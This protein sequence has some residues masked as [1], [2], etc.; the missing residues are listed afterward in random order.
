[1]RLIRNK[2]RQADMYAQSS[3]SGEQDRDAQFYSWLIERTPE[4]RE[5]HIRLFP[6]ILKSFIAL[7]FVIGSYL[8]WHSDLDRRELVFAKQLVYDVLHQDAN[9]QAFTAWYNEKA[10]KILF[11]PS[12]TEGRE[13]LQAEEY[14]V[15]VSSNSITRYGSIQQG[16]MIGTNRSLPVEVVKEGWVT[17][18]GQK[19]GVG[20]VVVIDHGE[21]EE[22]WYGQLDD[23]QVEQYDW[24]EQG[25]MIGYTT[26]HTE[27]GEGRFYFAIR[28]NATFI[29]P[30]EVI[31][32]E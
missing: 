9:I 11:L 19:E 20:T 32:F 27:S 28:R 1:M 26:F 15:P 29:D 4:E 3:W 5:D 22:A 6:V 23:I 31:S 14:A 13:Q 21:G 25:D 10:E 7:M 17:F 12:F 2:Q 24:V 18:V 30:L 8:L 16:I